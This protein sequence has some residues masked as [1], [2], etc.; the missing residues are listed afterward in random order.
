MKNTTKK[1]LSLFL[2]M[3]M[4]LGIAP[5]SGFVGLEFPEINFGIKAEAEEL[6][7]GIYIY[8]VKDGEAIITD[9]DESVSGD[10]VIPSTLG[11]YPVIGIDN[12]AF[13]YCDSLTTVKIPGSVTGIG[14]LVF[15]DCEKLESINVDEN[16]VYYSSDEKG[17]L[18][19]KDKTILIQCP[20]GII[21]EYVI[22][23]SVTT[24]SRSAFYECNRLTVA[25]IPDNVTN[26]GSLAFAFCDSLDSINVDE[27]N[28]YYSSDEYGVLFD[29]DK[30]NLIQCP[31]GKSGDYTVPDS[32]VS[33]G[34]YAFYGCAR[35]ATVT[36]PDSVIEIETVA[37]YDC[38]NLT[39]VYYNGTEEE[40]NEISISSG[41]EDLLNATIHFFGEECEHIPG[42]AVKEN[43]V[44]PTE[45]TDGYYDLVVYC[46]VCGEELSR[47]RIV[48][49]HDF[50]TVSG[51][52][53]SFGA[54]NEITIN[55]F[56]EGSDE[57]A[58]S[59][60]V[61]GSEY[62]IDG[63]LHG[64]YTV[65]VSKANHATRT[66]TVV[67]G[68]EDITQNFVINVLG[69]VNADGIVDIIDV[70]KQNAHAKLVECIDGYAL[71][72]ADINGD[73]KVNT[74]DIARGHAHVKGALLLHDVRE[75]SQGTS[76]VSDVIVTV[77]PDRTF[78]SAGET[79][80]YTVKLSF[81]D[82]ITSFQMELVM[83]ECLTY[84]D[85]SGLGYYYDE[86]GNIYEEDTYLRDA[87]A[88]IRFDDLS[89]TEWS[90]RTDAS[91]GACMISGF[92]RNPVSSAEDVILAKFKVVADVDC[93]RTTNLVTLDNVVFG[94]GD[95]RAI[96]ADNIL[97]PGEEVGGN[98]H[99]CAENLKKIEGLEPDCYNDGVKTHYECICTRLYLD[100]TAETKTTRKDVILPSP[101][102]IPAE[103]V[104][105]NRVEPTAEEDGY[106][107]LVVYCTVCGEELSRKR[108]VLH[109]NFVT[110]SGTVT[111]H[112]SEDD[113]TVN[114]FAEGSDEIAYSTTV[115]GSGEQ[116]Y[117]I[118]EVLPGTYTV[119][120]S[121]ANH[122]TRTYTVVVGDE[123][124]TQDFVINLSG[125][126]NG[127][128]KVNAIDV[129]RANAHAK[130]TKALTGYEFI[131]V[132][133]NGDGK[134]N[135][136]DV[137]LINA[138]A[139]GVRSLW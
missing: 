123:D 105:E 126:M 138:H 104:E 51:T 46:T 33:I 92:G 65:E 2:V 102:H 26:I 25:K 52:V 119:E 19:N 3:T 107:D 35:L 133:I 9:C 55:F 103:A 120:V 95:Y 1:L 37:F 124:I 110:V 50:V 116:E 100:E 15:A 89:W 76:M 131:C 69:D 34:Y 125:D 71:A 78:A 129:A 130:G 101:G 59:T 8:T 108:I 96:S 94:D 134:V 75:I 62:A 36:I 20:S 44:E 79:I 29:K 53:T 99:V 24:I 127:D 18:F 85:G 4:T 61:T 112:G 83:P 115:T 60:T 63:V 67:V 11:G 31:S 98:T 111:S 58:Y 14:N 10:I 45:D 137:A 30:I 38:T 74:V 128:G 118:D 49:H 73:T 114:F 122:I 40:W 136:I 113:V 27:N 12:F 139:K 41:N 42:E 84:V 77:T 16:N 66:Y 17:V 91:Q 72:C 22:P 109:H 132:D 56:A 87:E 48:L 135:A 88:A 57:I 117:A 81:T 90:N 47:K 7:E 70:S 6:T 43:I 68:N 54:Q 97:L 121:K 64:T 93:G 80:T 86:Y 106:Y 28:V 39:D 21:G 82:P 23:D 32:V 13:A 5:L